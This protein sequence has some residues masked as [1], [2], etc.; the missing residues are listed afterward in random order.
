MEIS[1]FAQSLA[2]LYEAKEI[3]HAKVNELLAEKKITAV[4]ADFILKGE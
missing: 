3:T 2:R 1:A 4:E